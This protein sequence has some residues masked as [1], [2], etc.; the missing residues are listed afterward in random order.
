VDTSQPV[1]PIGR[2]DATAIIRH[3]LVSFMESQFKNNNVALAN[4]ENPVLQPDST[5]DFENSCTITAIEEENILA[6]NVLFPNPAKDIITIKTKFENKMSN[7]VITDITG[8]NITHLIKIE[9]KNSKEFILNL[10]SINSGNY[11]IYFSNNNGKSLK[12][13][14]I[15]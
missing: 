6:E 12:C 10:S 5:A 8:R 2:K 3:Y 4:F 7:I 11:F 1:G 14:V 9:E 13:T 15:K